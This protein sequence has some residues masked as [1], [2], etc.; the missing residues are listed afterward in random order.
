[1][2]IRILFVTLALSFSVSAQSETRH[3]RNQ[4]D[5]DNCRADGERRQMRGGHGGHHGG[6]H[7]QRGGSGASQS[8][9]AGDC[10]G[11]R[12]WN[13][14]ETDAGQVN[15]V[16]VS[17]Q[18]LNN[19]R[20]VYTD[21]CIR[22]HGQHGYGDGPDAKDLSV[23][24]VNLRHAVRMHSDGELSYMIRSGRD[25]MPAWNDK[26]S[27]TQVW[28]VI[29]YTR[30]EIGPRVGQPRSGRVL[31]RQSSSGQP[32]SGRSSDIDDHHASHKHDM[33]RDMEKHHDD[34]DH[35]DMHDDMDHG[36]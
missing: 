34:M 32:G 20:K 27:D 3:A 31:D 21:N 29:N 6:G 1:M 4:H 9:R 28:D 12:H 24:P 2:L 5:Y 15:P 22:C 11:H 16:E 35:G 36:E 10:T 17:E 23:A 19:G 25:P 30:F 8:R 26:L 7:R 14:P 13:V 33:D 18:S